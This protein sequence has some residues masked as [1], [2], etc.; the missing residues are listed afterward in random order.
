MRGVAF[1]GGG[2]V[3]IWNDLTEDG[4]TAVLLILLILEA[5]FL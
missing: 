4:K 5:L 2:V 3:M 1:R